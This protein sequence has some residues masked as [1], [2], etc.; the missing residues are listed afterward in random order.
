M[1][2]GTLNQHREEVALGLGTMHQTLGEQGTNI[3]CVKLFKWKGLFVAHSRSHIW[4]MKVLNLEPHVYLLAQ[5]SIH[6]A[7]AVLALG[8]L[9]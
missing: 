4:Q 5:C 8:L 7:L 9:I 2:L 1:D 3:Y 6:W